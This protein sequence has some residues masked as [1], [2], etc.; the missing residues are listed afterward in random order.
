MLFYKG[1][2]PISQ[3]LDLNYSSIDRSY[4]TEQ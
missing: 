2:G 1:F 3:Y 4:R